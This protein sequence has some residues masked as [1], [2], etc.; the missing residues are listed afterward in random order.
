MISELERMSMDALVVY[1]NVPSQKLPRW[2]EEKYKSPE[3]YRLLDCKA[4]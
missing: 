4:M 3:K 2:T 1:L